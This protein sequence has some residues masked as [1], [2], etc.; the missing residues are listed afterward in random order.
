AGKLRSPSGRYQIQRVGRGERPQE[1]RYREFVQ[2]D[3]DVIDRAATPESALAPHYEAEIPLVIGDALGALPIP[4]IRIQVN[5]R[6]VCEGYYRGVGV[7]DPQAALRALDKLDKIGPARVAALLGV[8][9]R[10]D[11]WRA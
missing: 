8:P 3:I 9:A 6:K 5:N 2:A 11:E 10:T 1:G 7:P 4:P